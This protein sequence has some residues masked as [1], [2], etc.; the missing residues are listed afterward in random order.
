MQTYEQWTFL[1]KRLL[2]NRQIRRFT[3]IVSLV[4]PILLVVMWCDWE[5]EMSL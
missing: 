2:V 1:T 3:G 5:Y 4:A